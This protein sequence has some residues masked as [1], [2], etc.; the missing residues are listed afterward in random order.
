VGAAQARVQEQTEGLDWS[1]LEHM[2]VPLLN[3]MSDVIVESF[4]ENYK[5]LLDILSCTPDCVGDR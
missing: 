2:A 1:E 3:I 5:D 4:V